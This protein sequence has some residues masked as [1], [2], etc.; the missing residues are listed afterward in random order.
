MELKLI[1]SD[2]NLTGDVEISNRIS[3]DH[4]NKYEKYEHWKEEAMNLEYTRKTWMQT[5]LIH[6]KEYIRK[7]WR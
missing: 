1:C 4:E 2:K 5:Y 3:I 7:V 6:N